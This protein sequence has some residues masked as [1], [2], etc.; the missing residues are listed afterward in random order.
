MLHRQAGALRRLPNV[1][2]RPHLDQTGPQLHRTLATATPAKPPSTNDPFANGTN[3]YY[4]E[5]MYRLWRQDPKSV[6]VSWNVYFSGMD[7]KGLSSPQAFQP[8]PSIVPMPSGGAPALHGAGGAELDDHLRVSVVSLCII[9]WAVV[10]AIH[11]PGDTL[12]VRWND[13]MVEVDYFDALSALFRLLF[14]D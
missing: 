9:S 11:Q 14:G 13:R 4:V 3:A 2:L 12:R 7:K 6:H 1:A 10:K 8:P 5:E